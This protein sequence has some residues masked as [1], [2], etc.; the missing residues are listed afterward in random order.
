MLALPALLLAAASLVVRFRRARGVE[1]L[2]LKWFTYAAA[3]AG[4]GLA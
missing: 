2:Q 3:F 1:R 4:V